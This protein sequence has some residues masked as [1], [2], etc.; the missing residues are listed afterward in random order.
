[1]AH[2]ETSM[3]RSVPASLVER[4]FSGATPRQA[5]ALVMAD[6]LARADRVRKF[7]QKDLSR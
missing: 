6:L 7:L 2:C 5:R 4:N 3:P 1:M